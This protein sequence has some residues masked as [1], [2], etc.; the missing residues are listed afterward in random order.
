MS[1]KSTT[2][3]ARVACIV[4]TYNGCRELAR[5]L[6][7][8]DRQATR[9]D[10]FV[11]DSSSSDG[12]AE[13]ARSRVR[14]V[15]IIPREQFNH[16]GTR[17]MVVDQNPGYDFY[18]FLT[19]DVELV[20]P[21]AIDKLL[22][23][24]ADDTVAVVYGRQIPHTDATPLAAHARFFNYPQTSQLKSM[25]DL[26]ALGLKTTFI[27]NSFSAYRGRALRDI[28]GFPRNVIST[29][30]MF[31]AAKL[32]MAGWKIA[33]SAE[34]WCRH[35][36][37]YSLYEEFT[38]YFDQGVFH[39]RAP[40]IRERFGGAGGEGARYVWSELK[41]LGLRRWYLWPGSLVRNV[42]KLV[43]FHLGRRE[44]LLPKGLKKKLSMFS[45]YWDSPLAGR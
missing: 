41:F 40:W 15:T 4:P 22:V 6:D 27:S 29:E 25:A 17:Q 10:L 42:L 13:L 2:E 16:G 28:G 19:Q 34:A 37:N 36:H 24:F 9:F 8:L 39:A 3:Q 33:Y 23:P 11:V 38:R 21:D 14:D 35:S 18:M 30:D 7:S 12:T 45:R 1:D 26:P 43:A 5:L 20:D 31:I 32:L 44:R